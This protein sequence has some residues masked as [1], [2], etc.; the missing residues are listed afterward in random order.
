MNM[1]HWL[2]LIGLNEG[3]KK[4]IFRAIFPNSFQI[5]QN[6]FP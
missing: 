3:V 6:P 2:K 4:G 1:G 5:C